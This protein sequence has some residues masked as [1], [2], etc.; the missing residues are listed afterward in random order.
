MYMKCYTVAEA[1]AQ[2]TSL[3]NA[4]GRG[5]EVEITREDVIFRLPA[6]LRS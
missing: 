6:E 3:L 1:R 2:F 4:V 5:E